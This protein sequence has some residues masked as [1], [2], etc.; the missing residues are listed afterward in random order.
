MRK[1]EGEASWRE[2][3]IHSGAG[4]DILESQLGD[5]FLELADISVFGFMND[6]SWP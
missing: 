4:G 1:N 6:G 5:L 2:Q 3:L